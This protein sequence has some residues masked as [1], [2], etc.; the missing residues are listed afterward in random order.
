M[1]WPRGARRPG[2]LPRSCVLVLLANFHGH[3][4]RRAP[5]CFRGGRKGGLGG[6]LEPGRDF[7]G[8]GGFRV[9]PQSNSE[10]FPLLLFVRSGVGGI[11]TSP[12][13]L[14][15]GVR[16]GSRRRN[17]ATASAQA[18]GGAEPKSRRAAPCGRA[19]RCAASMQG[20]PGVFAG[21]RAAPGDRNGPC[22]PAAQLCRAACAGELDHRS[23]AVSRHQP[24][25][26][27]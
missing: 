21:G 23:M 24:E 22:G 9:S 8:P 1:R 13:C 6:N 20:M 11:L 25:A 10:L 4:V 3:G 17:A 7:P 27:E 19:L 14:V 26:S 16:S 15:E 18:G 5:R 12:S 2:H